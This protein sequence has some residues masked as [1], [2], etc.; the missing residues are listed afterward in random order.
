MSFR[1]LYSIDGN[2]IV[3][4]RGN[5]RDKPFTIVIYATNKPV[6]INVVYNLMETVYIRGEHDGRTH[7]RRAV[8]EALDI[9]L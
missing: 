4:H 5:Y 7:V 3:E 8:K 1:N 2:S 6:D 9:E